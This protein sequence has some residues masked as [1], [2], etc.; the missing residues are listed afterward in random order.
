MDL[1][2]GVM[3]KDPPESPAH[4]ENIQ[5]RDELAGYINTFKRLPHK[6]VPQSPRLENHH[7]NIWKGEAE[8]ECEEEARLSGIFGWRKSSKVATHPPARAGVSGCRKHP[9]HTPARCPLAGPGAQFSRPGSFH[10][11]PWTWVCVHTLQQP[12]PFKEP[13]AGGQRVCWV[14]CIYKGGLSSPQA[15][16]GKRLV[17]RKGK[18]T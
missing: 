17:A 16:P 1:W 11:R 9:A 4:R 7:T 3:R 6:G 12:C 8:T 5:E 14:L 15:A 13:E 2:A 10:Q 18:I